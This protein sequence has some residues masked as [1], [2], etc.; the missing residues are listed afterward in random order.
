MVPQRPK[1]N[2]PMKTYE[3]KTETESD[4]S[5]SGFSPDATA[6]DP[7]SLSQNTGGDVARGH[8][9]AKKVEC[10]VFWST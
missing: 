7:L 1:L 4:S 3:R 2:I 9:F 10:L 8:A 5:R 6:A